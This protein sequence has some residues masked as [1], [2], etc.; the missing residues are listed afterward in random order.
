M[1]R[2]VLAR[3]DGRVIVPD[4]ELEIPSGQRLRIEIQT[5]EADPA[6]FADLSEFAADLPDAPL[7]LASQHDHYLYGTV[8]Q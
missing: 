1:T 8:K 6:P 3:Y 2:T 7:D 4:E 5:I